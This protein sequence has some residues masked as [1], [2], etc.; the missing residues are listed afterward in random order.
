[1][2]RESRLRYRL[3]LP[4]REGEVVV[5]VEKLA[6]SLILSHTLEGATRR[7]SARYSPH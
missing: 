4:L 1:V 6:N 5:S 7:I 2:R 3:N